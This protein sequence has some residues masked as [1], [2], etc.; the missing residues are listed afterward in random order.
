MAGNRPRIGWILGA[1]SAAVLVPWLIWGERMDALLS[2]QAMADWAAG[3][4]RWLVWLA[5]VGLLMADVVLP[6]PATVVMS[7]LGFALGPW[8]GGLV[9][10]TGAFLAGCLAYGLARWLGRGFAERLAGAEALAE[11]EARF[12]R[13]GGWWVALSRWTPVLPEAVACLAGLSRMSPPRFAAALACGC[14]PLGLAFAWIGH[15]GQSSPALALGLSAAIP[16]LLWWAASR[17][18]GGRL[19]RPSRSRNSS[20]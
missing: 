10:A 8:E 5:G 3:R 12:A 2:P 16:G 6:V 7:A 4:P 13:L 14:A 1:V 17:A 19:S 20:G 9:A 15:L 11:L 18:P